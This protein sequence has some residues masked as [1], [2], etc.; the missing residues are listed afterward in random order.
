M[1]KSTRPTRRY[2][3]TRRRAQAGQTR[4]RIIEA[5]TR[6]FLGSGY[7]GA[8]IPRIA[9]DAGVAVETVY[10]SA[11]GKAGLLVAAVQAAL[12]GSAEHGDLPVEERPGIRRVIEETDPSRQLALYAATLPGVHRRVGPLLRVLDAAAASE[13]ALVAVRDQMQAGRLD[14][15]RG[16]AS[17]LA[18]RGALRPGLTVQRAADVL[19]TVCAESNYRALVTAREWTEYDYRDWVTTTLQHALLATEPA[20]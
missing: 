2:D 9:E 1:S 7:A 11:S 6:A 20:C 19:W 16:F 12:A 17:L 14:G 3:A 4:A 18:E 5:A 8:T 15:M 13:D 10:R